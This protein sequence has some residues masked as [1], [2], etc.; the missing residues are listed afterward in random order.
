M[1]QFKEQDHSYTSISPDNIQW[2]SVTKVISKYKGDFNQEAVAKKC[3][4]NKNSKWFG[5][6]PEEILSIWN[7]ETDRSLELG[8]WFHNARENDLL[9]FNS[10]RRSGLDLPIYHPLVQDGVKQAP[11]QKL[12]PGIYPEHMV[13]L[14][15]AGICGQADRIEV[16]NGKVH[17]ADYK[18]NKEIKKES[19]VDWEGVSKKMKAP[20]NN[21]DDCNYWHYALQMSMY[22]YIILKH[23]FKLQPGNITLEHIIFENESEDENGY[24]VTKYDHTGNPIVKDIVLYHMPYLESEVVAIIK[25]LK[26]GN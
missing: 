23:N 10:V 25:D 18:T 15:S 4:K 8:T 11:N 26:N 20:V 7:K 12:D 9:S 21:L 5:K 24:P 6:T 2:K 19:Y 13:Y 22:M 16:Y 3:S 14:K 1:I 17:V